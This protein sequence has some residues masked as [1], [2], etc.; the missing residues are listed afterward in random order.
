MAIAHILKTLTVKTKVDVMQN[1]SKVINCKP[2][3]K[4]NTTALS[5][6]VLSILP[7]I[8]IAQSEIQGETS[9]QEVVVT[10]QRREQN[11][12]SVGITMS[13]FSNTDIEARASNKLSDLTKLVSNTM[14]FEDYGNGLPT[15]VIRG[16]GL[17]DFSV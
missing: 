7:Q 2:K 8:V 17:Q 16:V 12:Q 9:I 10:A 6:A 3:L 15:W 5:I 14:L 1:P 11:L 13:A 4:T